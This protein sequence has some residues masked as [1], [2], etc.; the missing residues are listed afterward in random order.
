MEKMYV[1]PDRPAYRDGNYYK[2]GEPFPLPEEW[3]PPLG[4]L[5]Y[6]DGKSTRT[7]DDPDTEPE[8]EPDGTQDPKG[9]VSAK[10]KSKSF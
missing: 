2:P 4:A 3:T 8:T 10:S 7:S 5:T 1:L 9:T 6:P